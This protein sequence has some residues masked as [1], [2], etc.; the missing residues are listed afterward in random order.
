M[1]RISP[2]VFWL[3]LVSCSSV[4]EYPEAPFQEAESK[5]HFVREGLSRCQ[6]FVE[7]W[8]AES[9]PGTGLIPRN[10]ERD[11]DLWV[12]NDSAA[13]NYP[14]MV[15]TTF[16]TDEALFRGRMVDILETE[17]KL[18]NRLGPLPDTYR[19]SEGEFRYEQM[20]LDRITFGA[21]EYVKDGLLPVT[22]LLGP[23]PWSKRL[24]EMLDEIW[25][26]ASFDTPYGPIVSES[27]EVNGEMLQ[28]LSRIYW[29]TGDE[30]YL[31]WALRLGDY[32]LL[33]NHHPTR[34]FESLR[35]RDHGCEVV[36]GLCELYATLSV[37]NPEKQ[38]E[39]KPLLHEML[40]R[41]LEVGRNS[42][43]LFYNV[44]DPRDGTILNEALADTFGYTLN[45][46]YTVYLVDHVERYR[47]A[48]I[49][50]L[51]ALE[52]GYPDYSWEEG[53]ADGDADAIES[54]L[55]LYNREPIDS[56]AHWID[57]QIQTMWSK[58]QPSGVIEGWHGD[59]NFARTTLMYVLWKSAGVY[60]KPWR[61]DLSWGA[62]I[63]DGTLFLSFAA[64][65]PWKGRVFFDFDRHRTGMKLPFDWPRINQFPEW[66]PVKK[67]QDYSLHLMG[68]DRIRIVTGSELIDGIDLELQPGERRLVVSGPK[69]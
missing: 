62:T 39:Y 66:Y 59:G 8:L 35:L 6:R 37:A 12:P 24:L 21:S 34:D 47:A 1:R 3:L 17:Q 33:G 65:G 40:D 36:S 27:A 15:L 41:I 5:S 30:K 67:D 18:T 29:M 63:Q 56:S 58:Q 22:E 54:A 43:G 16:Y 44:I 9:D 52:M 45:G 2:W 26:Q 10:L 28:T 69:G 23:T 38:E 50:V 68:E 64:E 31:E 11:R 53:S 49:Q 19:F 42:D 55:N 51:E 25:A 48:V 57:R 4:P 46:Y 7:G 61:D 32:Y 14:F 60:L 20:D 13:D